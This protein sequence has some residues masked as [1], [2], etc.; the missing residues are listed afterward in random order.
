MFFDLMTGKNLGF[1][2]F[3]LRKSVGFIVCQVHVLAWNGATRALS[4][5]V[6]LHRFIGP[7]SSPTLV[8]PFGITDLAL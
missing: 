3:M 6:P 4:I 1:V 2:N 7:D 8:Q 5:L